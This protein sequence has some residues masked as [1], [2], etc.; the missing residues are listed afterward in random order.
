MIPLPRLPS[1]ISRLVGPHAPVPT[2]RQIYTAVLDGAISANQKRNGRYEIDART[3][4]QIIAHFGLE[5]AA[6]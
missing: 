6:A 2:Y 5:R 4:P 1:E 3:L